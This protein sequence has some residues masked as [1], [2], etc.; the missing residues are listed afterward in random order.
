MHL[1]TARG[2]EKK[3]NLPHVKNELVSGPMCHLPKEV[4]GIMNAVMQILVFL[5]PILDEVHSVADSDCYLKVKCMHD[6]H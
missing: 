3:I 4:V 2:K 5:T 1:E 6:D